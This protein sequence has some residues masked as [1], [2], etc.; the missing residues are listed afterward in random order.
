MK[1]DNKALY[2]QI[3]K[4]VAKEVKKALNEME[5]ALDYLP[6]LSVN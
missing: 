1:R 6:Q 2:E 5:S 3:M 4:S